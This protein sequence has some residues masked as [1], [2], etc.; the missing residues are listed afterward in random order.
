MT[1]GKKGV[2]VGLGNNVVDMDI[3]VSSVPTEEGDC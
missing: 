1:I 3:E 2:E